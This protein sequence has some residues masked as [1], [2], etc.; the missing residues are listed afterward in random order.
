MCSN[1]SSD[2]GLYSND[3]PNLE[4]QEELDFDKLNNEQRELVDSVL[5][6]VRGGDPMQPRYVYVDAPRGSG[7]TF[8]FNMIAMYLR[9]NGYRVSCATWTGIAATLL[10]QGRTVHSLFKLP[11][12]VI[13][14][15][16][17]SILPNS[18]QANVLRN[19]NEAPLVRGLA[20]VA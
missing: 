15:S 20:A 8:V 16:S 11:V 19:Q 4:H 3:E 7:K 18:D 12:P 13:D 14:T 17:L 5:Q 9:Q 2:N 6:A 10:T 1:W